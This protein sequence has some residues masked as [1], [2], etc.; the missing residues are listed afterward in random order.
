MEGARLVKVREWRGGGRQAATATGSRGWIRA[1][2]A[3]SLHRSV[4]AGGAMCTAAAAPAP[5]A[6]PA[7]PTSLPASAAAACSQESHGRKIML[8]RSGAQVYA[9]D[10]H[11][12]HMGGHLWEGD[13]EDV[14]GHKCVV[15]P[16]HK[17]R[18]RA[19]LM[20]ACV[21]CRVSCCCAILCGSGV[22]SMM[23]GGG[24]PVRCAH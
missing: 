19:C 23:G 3:V 13:I 18:V 17:Y 11:C 16:M 20:D 15:C 22:R 8:V 1:G 9:T 2:A 14:D 7:A 10:A 24:R 5:G 6:P 21:V 12:F 4:G